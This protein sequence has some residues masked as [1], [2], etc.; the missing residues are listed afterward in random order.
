MWTFDSVS[1]SALLYLRS[2]TPPAKRLQLCFIRFDAH[3]N[4]WRLAL[5]WRSFPALSTHVF[6][7]PSCP[8]GL[9]HGAWAPQRGSRVCDL[10]L[11]YI[12]SFIMRIFWYPL[13]SIGRN[14]WM[15]SLN[16]QIPSFTLCDYSSLKFS[17]IEW[18]MN[19][20]AQLGSICFHFKRRNEADRQTR[21]MI[22]IRTNIF[23]LIRD[24]CAI[25]SMRT[26]SE[27]TWPKEQ[28]II[29]ALNKCPITDSL[30]IK[31]Q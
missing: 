13:P 29:Q 6:Y 3:H 16:H 9:G 11:V 21:N 20:W 30:L 1:L 4:A 8:R 27:K 23:R 5:R 24:T 18:A 17:L 12:Y 19:E 7:L 26:N 25:N 10:W 15:T 22:A 14:L 2:A 28:L 31:V